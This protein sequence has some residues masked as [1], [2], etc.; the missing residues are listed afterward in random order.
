MIPIPGVHKPCPTCR[1]LMINPATHRC[2]TVIATPAKR[3]PLLDMLDSGIVK[4]ASA[5]VIGETI[6][7]ATTETPVITNT[8]PIVMVSR[9]HGATIVPPAETV[10]DAF[11]KAAWQREYMRAYRA[12]KKAQSNQ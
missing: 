7:H 11:D 5:L 1:V 3:D 6:N 12:K 10:N 8:S 4:P 9:K 2:K